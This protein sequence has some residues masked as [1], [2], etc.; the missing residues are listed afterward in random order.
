VL[1]TINS[2]LNYSKKLSSS[3]GRISKNKTY[4]KFNIPYG[5]KNKNITSSVENSPNSFNNKLGR[6]FYSPNL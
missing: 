4:S 3:S 2:N 5:T 1:S 6:P